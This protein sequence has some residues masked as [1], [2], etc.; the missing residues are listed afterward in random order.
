MERSESGLK[1]AEEALEHR[2][3]ELTVLVNVAN[4]LVQPGSF[5]E[6]VVRVLEELLPIAQADRALFL[7]GDDRQE[8]LTVVAQAGP[9]APESPT[10][11]VSYESASGVAF[12]EGPAHR[13]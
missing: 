1:R 11:S 6:R 13:G 2:N 12:Q 7:V 10:I 9:T 3:Q 5:E 8:V 4:I